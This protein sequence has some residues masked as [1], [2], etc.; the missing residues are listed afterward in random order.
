MNKIDK[1]KKIQNSISNLSENEILELFKIIDLNSTNYTKNNNGIF[2]NL[3]W[4]SDSVIDEID[5]YINFCIKSQNEISKYE[6]MKSLLNE[7]IK[8]KDKV[9]D[10]SN[11]I[12]N[13]EV[14][15]CIN[16]KPKISSSMKF[17]FL[18]K[19]FLK[20][21]N[22]QNFLIDNNLVYEDYIL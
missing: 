22:H 6:N 21:H 15:V 4:V 9:I 10:P 3:N 12:E 8:I 17:F 13:T 18:K 19:K 20:Q 1:C 14:V 16:N 5:A 2:I 11:I 7:S